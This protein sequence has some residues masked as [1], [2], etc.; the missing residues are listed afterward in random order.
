MSGFSG[1][2]PGVTIF[3]IFR[4]KWWLAIPLLSLEASI[5]PMVAVQSGVMFVLDYVFH[6]VTNTFNPVLWKTKFLP[7]L[8]AAVISFG[9]MSMK[10]SGAH[11]E[12]GD[13]IS[14]RFEMSKRI[15][16]TPQGRSSLIPVA[17]LWSQIKKSWG[18][19]FHPA[20]LLAAYFFLGKRVFR[21]PRGLY[22]LLLSGCL[23]YWLADIFMMQLYFPNRYL[24][25]AF[26]VFMALAGG[27][28]LAAIARQEKKQT[29]V[30]LSVLLLAAGLY[31]F[32]EKLQP[33]S[34][35]T[36]RYKKH[37]LYAFIR[38]LPG[39]P[40]IAAHPKL[41]SEIPLTTGKS[42]LISRELSHPWWTAY[43][44]I[45]EKRTKD[46]FTAYYATEKH[47]IRSFIATYQ[48]DYWIV[49]HEHFTKPY[50]QHKYFYMQPFNFWINYRLRP[51]DESLLYNVPPHN[52]LYD[53]SQYF[54]IASDDLLSWLG[55]AVE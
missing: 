18:N 8:L 39:R 14:S 24:K 27:Y 22:A 15:E 19:A 48:I 32:H 46:F 10:Y 30:W 12:F 28:W 3:I 11:H 2:F 25:H 7:L 43:W 5:Y 16:F 13:L 44:K 21:L 33:R 51:S 50:L 42:V 1:F 47:H 6:D 37:E 38:S 40:M 36:V 20:L 55:N 17:P 23:L 53:D 9:V 52:R 29:V 49:S 34:F 31:E 35:G 45:I 26:P 41:A 4:K 54:V